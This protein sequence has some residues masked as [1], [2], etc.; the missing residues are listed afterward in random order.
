MRG[1]M[2]F[3]ALLLLAGSARPDEGMWLLSQESRKK[4]DAARL[5][6]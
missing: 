2:A 3:T 1:A 6:P 5:T 4:E